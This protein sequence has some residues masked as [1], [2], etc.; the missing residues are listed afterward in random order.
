[1]ILIGADTVPI[2]GSNIKAQ[3]ETGEGDGLADARP[4]GDIVSEEQI[5]DFAAREECAG[6][7]RT[8]SRISCCK[9]MQQPLNMEH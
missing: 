4:N 8:G 1:M 5:D 9:K 3:G 2:S 7:W 6:E